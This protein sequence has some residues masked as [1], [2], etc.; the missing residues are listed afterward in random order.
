MNDYTL[1]EKHRNTKVG[2]GVALL[3]Q[4]SIEF[5][6]RKD[7]GVF[8]DHIESIFIE[9]DNSQFDMGKNIIVGVIYRPPGTDINQFKSITCDIVSQISRE[10][11][12]CYLMGDYNI[13]ILN[14]EVHSQT[15]DFID[16]M[17]SYSLVPLMNRPTRI[18][19][20][21]ATLIDNIFSNNLHDLH[22][23]TQAILITDISDHLPIIHINWNFKDCNEELSIIRRSN[24]KKNREE[25][26]QTM[27]DIN[28]TELY[29]M[30]DTQS[31]FSYFHNVI[32]GLHDKHFP[33]MQKN[34]RHNCRKPW[35]TT[36]LKNAIKTKN[37][38]H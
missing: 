2:G 7:L 36:G 26:K 3:C 10:T 17:Y 22:K 20:N 14:N 15:S 12:I 9:I 38:L 4:E 23:S 37:K 5:I 21:S 24:T 11:K 28:W 19:N 1:V 30:S 33:K 32:K 8:N 16:L 35:L 31:A 27:N 18:T 13:N 25:F 29:S 34:L 6:E